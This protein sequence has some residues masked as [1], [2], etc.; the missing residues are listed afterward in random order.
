MYTIVNNDENVTTV[1][2]YENLRGVKFANIW[3][4]PTIMLN[5]VSSRSIITRLCMDK[6]D[7]VSK[8]PARPLLAI[9]KSGLA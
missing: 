5:Y 4:L 6:I 9:C 8:R 3:T 7:S 1:D 2:W